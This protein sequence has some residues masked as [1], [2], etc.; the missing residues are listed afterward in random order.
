[1][2]S[3]FEKHYGKFMV[4]VALFLAFFGLGSC[5]QVE[6][7]EVV[8]SAT[9][10]RVGVSGGYQ[11]IPFL[12]LRQGVVG[13]YVVFDSDKGP[14]GAVDQELHDRF[15]NAK[16]AAVRIRCV[17]MVSVLERYVGLRMRQPW[18]V[19]GRIEE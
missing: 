3:V 18:Y 8:L 7:G 11:T 13:P 4:L 16:G 1:M 5:A 17:E 6:N 14:I 12:P 15:K 9:I 2:I 19:F 10:Q